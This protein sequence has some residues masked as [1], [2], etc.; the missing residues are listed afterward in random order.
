MQ[1]RKTSNE[2]SSFERLEVNERVTRLA[3]L[4]AREYILKGF[5]A[6]HLATALIT[7]SNTMLTYD[8][9]LSVIA[10]RVGLEV[11]S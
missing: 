2:W 8:K 9:K 6:T 5:D 7:R 11:L 4:L 10:K 1:F 3:G